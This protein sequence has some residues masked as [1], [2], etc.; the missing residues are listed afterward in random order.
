MSGTTSREIPRADAP[1]GGAPVAGL[2]FLAGG[3]T[4]GAAMRAFPWAGNPLGPADR[5]PQP[6]RTLVAVMLGSSQPM[7]IAWG[8]ER[9]V[10]YND[11]YVALLG[12]RHPAALG[13][14]FAAIWHDIM[15][16]VG[17]ILDRAYAGEGTHMDDISFVMDRRGYKEEAH[18]SFSYTPVRDEGGRVAGMFCACAETTEKVMAERRLLAERGRLRQLFEQAPGFVAVLRGPDHVFEFV[19]AAY[20]ELVG[21]DRDVTGRPVVEALPE[22]AEQ[23]F[24]DLLDGVYHSGRAFVG[25]QLPVRLQRRP[26]AEPELS[27]VDF[28]YQ[29]IVEPDGAVSGIF[30]QGTD[31]SEGKRAED[32]LRVSE[33]ALRRLNETLEARVEAR[34]AALRA[35]EA[36]LRQAQKMEAVGQLTG[37]IAHDFNN[38]LTGIGGSLSLLRRRL[39][40]G[41]T[42]GLE[43]YIEAA[44]GAADRAAALTHRLL[45][46]SRRQT[47]DPRPTDVNRL[48][49][50]MEE[51]IRRTV[52][53]AIAVETAP[54]PGLWPTLCDANQLE[55]ALLNLAINAR[56]AMPEGGRLRIA[57]ANVPLGEGAAAEGGLSRGDHV[58]IE[59]SDT[60]VGMAP[61]VAARAFDPFFTTKPLGQGTGLGLSMIYGFV[62]QSGG[63]VRLRTAP[64]EGT[65]VVLDLPRH[66][67]APPPVAA[68]PPAAPRAARAARGGTVL[69]VDDEPTVRM[70]VVEVLED[71][72]YAAIEAGD[73][74]AGLR[75]LQSGARVDLLVSDVGLPGG[76]NGRQLADAARIERPGLKVLLITGYA[77]AAVIGQ[78]GLGQEGL[79]QGGSDRWLQVMTKPFAV[80]ALAA[81]IRAMIGQG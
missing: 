1:A 50:G 36:E 74:A 25:R 22:V 43:R 80:D 9:I 33:Q 81:R 39:A 55:N 13:A 21:R 23:G 68:A 75:V 61:E 70:L 52:G 78:E 71:L 15:Q 79:G 76:M 69:V 17:P 12:R 34:T 16:D 35:A 31:V 8:P 4:M 28:V 67:V 59:V 72:G 29:P 7:F 5:W 30:V 24:T 56:D 49:A 46:F 3:G 2:D 41:R 51:L 11:G 66:A 47:L 53:P 20:A 6:L 32:A 38:L 19:N 44:Q 77:E 48:V 73:A 45:A 54:A 63:Q 65:T 18:F 58:S 10:L 37:G 40:A 26:G 64:G 60:G 42:E 14:R 27:Y 57:T 62:R